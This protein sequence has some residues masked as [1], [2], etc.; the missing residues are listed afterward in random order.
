MVLPRL[1]PLVLLSFCATSSSRWLFFNIYMSVKAIQFNNDHQAL[2]L[3]NLSTLLVS[4]IPK[5]KATPKNRRGNKI[6]DCINS[7]YADRFSTFIFATACS[8]LNF[9]LLKLSRTS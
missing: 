9:P 3:Y 5:K 4:D 6:S 2:F 1:K 8:K 7:I